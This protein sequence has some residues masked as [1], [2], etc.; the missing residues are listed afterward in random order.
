MP[1]MALMM[2]LMPLMASLLTMLPMPMPIGASSLTHIARST[3]RSFRL[4]GLTGSAS[5]TTRRTFWKAPPTPSS[6]HRTSTPS[7][8]QTRISLEASDVLDG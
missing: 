5:T 6:V 2:A 1:L 7:L 3:V 4:T 8:R